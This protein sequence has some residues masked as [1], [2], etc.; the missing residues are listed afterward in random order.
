[1][2][3]LIA[4]SEPAER[5]ANVRRPLLIL[6]AKN[7]PVLGRVAADAIAIAAKPFPY[8]K[9]IET[10]EGGHIGIIGR[11][12]QWFVNA[13]TNFFANAQHVPSSP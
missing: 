7:D 4:A 5:L 12:P 2:D 11:D 6:A 3:D 8:V 13:I 1:M 9:V 10:D